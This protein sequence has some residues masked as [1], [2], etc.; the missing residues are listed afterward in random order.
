MTG[1][2][3]IAFGFGWMVVA[4]LL[5]LYLGAKHEHHI[6]ALASAAAC[7]NLGEYHRV[8]EAYKWRSSVHAHSMLFSLSAVA[9]G[10]VLNSPAGSGVPRPDWVAGVLALTTVLWTVAAVR[11]I[12]P[13][14]GV[15][16]LLFLSVI[17][18]VALSMAL[19]H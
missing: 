10:L 19:I 18:V 8:F 17:A 15:A 6:K 16:D 2:L 12:R 11:R 7:G 1:N 13:L 9:V 14:M 3:L 4:A 5:G